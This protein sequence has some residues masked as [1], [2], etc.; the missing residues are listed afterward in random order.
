MGDQTLQ[1]RIVDIKAALQLL[2]TKRHGPRNHD[3]DQRYDPDIKIDVQNFDRFSCNPKSYLDWER[4][5]ERFFDCKETPEEKRFKIAKAKL[6]KKAETW[7]HE[8]QKQR[9]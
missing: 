6:T 3:D 4:S 8:I 1:Q 7:L 5:L 2:M 9:K